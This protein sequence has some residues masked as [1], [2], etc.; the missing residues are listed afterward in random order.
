MSAP[1]HP[2][3]RSDSLRPTPTLS[4]LFFASLFVLPRTPSFPR[5]R[6]VCLADHPGSLFPRIS[7][8]L[9]P[10]SRAGP[11][12]LLALLLFCFSCFFDVPFSLAYGA[13]CLF[14]RRLPLRLPLPGIPFCPS[15]DHPTPTDAPLVNRAC[16]LPLAYMIPLSP[17]PSVSAVDH[18]IP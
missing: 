10:P 5:G 12:P 1:C 6:V 7:L 18:L 16:P 15:A 9:H 14:G 17:A 11:P 2:D 4:R 13:P 8:R 3:L